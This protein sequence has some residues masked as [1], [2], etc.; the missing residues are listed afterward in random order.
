VKIIGKT[1]R[2]AV[3]VLG[4]VGIV[5]WI[6]APA[7]FAEANHAGW[8]H[9]T[10][11]E[12]HPNNES[13]TLRGKSGVHNLLLGGNGDDTIYAG[14]KGDIIW[15][16]REPEGQ[17]ESQ[18]DHLHGGPGTDW[19]Y[20]SHGTNYIWT[21]AGDD[22]VALVYGRGVVY[23]NGPGHKTLVMRYLPENRHY[24]LVGCNDI[25]IEPYRA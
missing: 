9:W 11:L 14:N 8:P 12:G 25:T 22:H 7:T 21:G 3:V 6:M 13:G 15:G 5:S 4:L 24:E 18:V 2:Y 20:A 10:N 1:S 17:P 16:D 23:C 19:I